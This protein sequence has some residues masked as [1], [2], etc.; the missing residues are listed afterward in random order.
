MSATIAIIQLPA[1]TLKPKGDRVFEIDF[2]RGF[3]IFLMVALHFCCDLYFINRFYSRAPELTANPAWVQAMKDFGALV[4]LT[5]EGGSLFVLEFFFSGLFMFLSG[6][7]C[8][9][10]H[11][12]IQRAIKL[13][14]VSI[15][16]TILLEGADLLLPSGNQIHIWLGILQSMA[17]A[18]FLYSVF[19]YFFPSFWADYAMAIVFVALV[20]WSIYLVNGPLNSE[21]AGRIYN[22]RFLT[23]KIP[24][25]GWKL[26]FGLRSYGD[27]YFS[28]ITTLALFF[29]GAVVGKTLYRGKHS[30]LPSWLPKKWA[31]P[32][33]WLG[34]HSL[35]VYLLHQPVCYLILLMILAPAGFG[36]PI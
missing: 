15:L 21:V 36:I 10:S 30:F 19:D 9:F 2:L 16:M 17:I 25:E 13:G 3:D 27:D 4:F 32:V 34:S 28:P 22:V 14:F 11:S 20:G 35:E 31:S 18:M 24:E 6:V 23:A 26:L 7:S 29:L 12:N 8:A 1:R 5:I 33:L